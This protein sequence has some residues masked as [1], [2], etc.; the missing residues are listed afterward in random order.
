MLDAW[1]RHVVCRGTDEWK[2]I[3]PAA[4]CAPDLDDQSI[5]WLAGP[6]LVNATADKCARCI[7]VSDIRCLLHVC[8]YAVAVYNQYGLVSDRVALILTG[9][10]N[11]L[12]REQ[13]LLTRMRT[14]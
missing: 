3:R 14:F 9:A 12:T 11:E 13:A 1:M 8:N 5:S 10:T 4:N 7:A 6:E 2:W